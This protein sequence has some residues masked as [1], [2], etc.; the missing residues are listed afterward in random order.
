MEAIIR[1]L[2]HVTATVGEPQADVD[3]SVG[4]LG[5]RSVTRTVNFDKPD[6]W[7]LCYDGAPTPF[8]EDA[9]TFADPSGPRIRLVGTTGDAHEPCVRPDTPAAMAVRGIHSVALPVADVARG[10][11]LLKMAV[12]GGDRA[13]GLHRRRVR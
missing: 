12:R 9:L 7:H 11:A 4:L 1:G 3:F 13:A 5:Q 6:V 2:H 8:G 10:T